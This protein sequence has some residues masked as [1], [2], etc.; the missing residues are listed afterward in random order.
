MYQDM[1]NHMGNNIKYLIIL[2]ILF[3][4][5]EQDEELKTKS[6]TIEDLHSRLKSNIENIQALNQQVTDIYIYPS[7]T[8]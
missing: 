6:T 5:I 7:N 3:F 2:L 1:L 8:D 4:R